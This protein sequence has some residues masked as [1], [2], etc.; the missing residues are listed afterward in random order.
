MSNQTH[1]G[2][3]RRSS[4]TGRIAL[5]AA[6]LG[7]VIFVCLNIVSAQV[8]RNAR[9]D[10]TQQHLYSL[11]Q[12]TRTH[13]RRPQGA[14]A[15]PPV[16]VVRAHQAGAAACR[17]RG[18]GA[19]VARFLRG[20]RQGQHH[21]RGHR[22]AAVLRGGGPRR[23]LRHRRLHRRRRRT[24]VL[25]PRRHQFDHRARHHRGVRAGPRSIPGIRPDAPGVGTRASR[26]A[27]GGAARRDRPRRQ[28][29]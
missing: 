20:R 7:A 26:Q 10:L 13:A 1:S 11:S 16:H 29:R 23:R 9:V 5:I 18:A 6:L 25:R 28:S 21:S 12:G 4:A 24:A 14:G 19:R 17:L 27:G 2:T 8:F 3:P 22:P 15:L